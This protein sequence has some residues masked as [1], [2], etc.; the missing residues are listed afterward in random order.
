MNE[1]HARPVLNGNLLRMLT[2]DF[3]AILVGYNLSREEARSVAAQALEPVQRHFQ[4]SGTPLRL[5]RL[6]VS[7]R[8]R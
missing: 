4:A 3:T 8:L 6:Q 5:L 7:E 2:E 1:Q